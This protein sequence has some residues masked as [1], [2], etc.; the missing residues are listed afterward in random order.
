M[1]LA[2]LLIR[3]ACDLAIP[4]LAREQNAAGAMMLPIPGAGFL[5][6]VEGLDRALSVP[7]IEDIAITAKPAEKLLPFPEG[8]SY[9]GFIFA[10]GATP[11]EVEQALRIAYRQLRLIIAPALDL[12]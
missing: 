4:S 2:E 5:Q 7:G 9:P 1:S 10:R 11:Q 12:L 6:R 3:H 8:A